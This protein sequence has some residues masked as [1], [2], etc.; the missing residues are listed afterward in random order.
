E[1]EL[2]VLEASDSEC[3]ER[4]AKRRLEAPERHRTD[5]EEMFHAVSAHYCAPGPEEAF[6][7]VI[8]RSASS[9]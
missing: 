3:L 1:H 8:H 4:L 9:P 7:V 5:T 6:H 2:H